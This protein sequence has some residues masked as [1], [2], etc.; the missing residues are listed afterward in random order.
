MKNI[1][2]LKP[3]ALVLGLV[4]LTLTLLNCGGTD[5]PIWTDDGGESGYLTANTLK[6]TY[7]AYEVAGLS[8]SEEVSAGNYQGAV[9]SISVDFKA[10]DSLAWFMVPNLGEG[11]YDAWVAVDGDT[12]M[13]SFDVAASEVTDADVEINNFINEQAD[14]Q[15]ELDAY[16]DSLILDSMPGFEDALSDKQVWAQIAEAANTEIENLDEEGKMALAQLLD[17]N[18]GIIEELDNMIIG[19]LPSFKRSTKKQC[20]ALIAQG[21]KELKE[22]DKWASLGTRVSAY[23]CSVKYVASH[24]DAKVT[25][26]IWVLFDNAVL[27][28]GMFALNTITNFVGRKLDCLT[29]EIQ[30]TTNKMGIAALLEELEEAKKQKVL[31]FRNGEPEALIAK[32]KFRSIGSD[33]RGTEGPIGGTADFFDELIGVYNKMVEVSEQPLVWRP[34][35][36]PKRYAVRKFNRFLSI[37]GASV[38][39]SDIA[40]IN[41]Q[42]RNDVWQA[43]FGND[44]TEEEPEFTFELIYDDGEVQLKHTVNAKIVNSN[45]IDD[46]I[47]NMV[48]VQGGTFTMGCTNSADPDCSWADNHDPHEVSLSSFSIG[49]FEITQE[50][51]EYVMGNNPSENNDCS[52]CPV[53]NVSFSDVQSFL[54]KLNSLSGK[55]FRLPTEAEWEFAARGGVE[56]KGYKY[57]GS[58]DINAVAWWQLSNG[59][60]SYPV[61]KKEANELGIY[62]MSG[63][64]SEWCSDWYANYYYLSSPKNNPKGPSTGLTR[65]LRGGGIET[66]TGSSQFHIRLCA[67]FLRSFLAP[68][69]KRRYAGFRVVFSN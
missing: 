58:N 4:A 61:G 30:E 50:L 68:S 23:W 16:V 38:S 26:K 44:G 63:N 49:K 27:G 67:V 45:P 55:S 56:S 65:V 39:N 18:K 60:N 51:W 48:F 22:G 46:L 8:F 34:G 53:E 3:V 54:S 43:A 35:F 69:Y 2:K 14:L 29:K 47:N 12:V 25:K 66:E 41:T 20:E 33:D 37:D 42:I 21:K 32:I 40:L 9:D 6:S 5:D 1:N 62:D 11:I 59:I 64:V 17:A 31:N 52:Q 24:K 13:F 15:K 19:S 7:K 28:P 36:E 57:A 10:E